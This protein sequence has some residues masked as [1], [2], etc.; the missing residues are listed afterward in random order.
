MLPGEPAQE[1]NADEQED[2]AGHC[3]EREGESRLEPCF[4]EAPG[5]RLDP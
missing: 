3:Q 4:G 5:G 2:A 1:E